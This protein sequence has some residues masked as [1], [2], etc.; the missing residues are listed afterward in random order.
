MKEGASS[1][2][3]P[4]ETSRGGRFDKNAKT[5]H[6][7]FPLVGIRDANESSRVEQV[8]VQA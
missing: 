1:H 2:A 4:Q 3:Q 8:N 6:K 5:P 7:N